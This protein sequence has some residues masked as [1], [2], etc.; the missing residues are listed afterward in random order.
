M[1][2]LTLVRMAAN[3]V[4]DT[5]VGSVPVAG[6][7]FDAAWKSN[8][9]NLDLLERHAIAPSKARRADGIFIGTLLAL[10]ALTCIV[11]LFGAVFLT[12]ALLRLMTGQ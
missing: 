10:V 4:L 12:G 7:V 2:R 5:A 9:R 3:I 11:L 6:D 1:P 8:T